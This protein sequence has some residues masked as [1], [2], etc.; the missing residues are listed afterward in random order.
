[1]IKKPGNRF[2]SVH[3]VSEMSFCHTNIYMVIT[4]RRGGSM[5]GGPKGVQK[6][7]LGGVSRGGRGGVKN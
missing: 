4:R 2:I 3:E 5:G 6:A 1:M 7:I